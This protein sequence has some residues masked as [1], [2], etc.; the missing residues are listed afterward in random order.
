MS[1][2]DRELSEA[3]RTIA[4]QAKRIA[5]VE[6]VLSYLDPPIVER[7]GRTLDD[8]LAQILQVLI[9]QYGNEKAVNRKLREALEPFAK[10]F[11]AE[12][13]DCNGDDCL[14]AA[15]VL[16]EASAPGEEQAT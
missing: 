11:Y 15:R 14:N 1:L 7:K 4:E 10:L 5:E 16:R 8:W 3:R 9:M 12:S 6:R 13:V 2:V